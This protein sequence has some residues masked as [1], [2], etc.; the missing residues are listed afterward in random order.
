[1]IV[2]KSTQSWETKKGKIESVHSPFSTI[3][4]KDIDATPLRNVSLNPNSKLITVEHLSHIVDQNNFTNL[5]LQTI[6]SQTQRIENSNFSTRI[7]FISSIQ[8]NKRS[9]STRLFQN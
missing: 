4:Y 3:K 9:S 5:Y 1:M 7:K 2:N 6:G 8:S